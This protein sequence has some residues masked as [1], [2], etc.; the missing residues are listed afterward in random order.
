MQLRLRKKIKYS[1]DSETEPNDDDEYQP[2]LTGQ[3]EEE[4]EEEEIPEEMPE[5]KED[6]E[7]LYYLSSSSNEGIHKPAIIKQNNYKDANEEEEIDEETTTKQPTESTS[8]S[9]SQP[10]SQPTPQPTPQ[11]TQQPTTEEQI[12]EENEDN[13]ES[14]GE[15]E[16]ITEVYV[17]VTKSKLRRDLL[18][19]RILEKLDQNKFE[20]TINYDTFYADLDKDTVYH[21]LMVTRRLLSDCLQERML[22][23]DRVYNLMFYLNAKTHKQPT[24]YKRP[25]TD[26]EAA[27]MNIEEAKKQKELE[28][29]VAEEIRKK[30]DFLKKLHNAKDIVGEEVIN[31]RLQSEELNL[32]TASIQEI[33]TKLGDLYDKILTAGSPK[34]TGKSA[35]K[36]DEDEEDEEDE[37]E[38]DEDEKDEESKSSGGKQTTKNRTNHKNTPKD[39]ETQLGGDDHGPNDN[40]DDGKKLQTDETVT[41][42]SPVKTVHPTTEEKLLQL[43]QHLNHLCIKMKNQRLLAANKST[44][45]SMDESQNFN[46]D[47]FLNPTSPN[48]NAKEDDVTAPTPTNTTTTTTTN[49]TVDEINMLFKGD[50][51]TATFLHHGEESGDDDKESKAPFTAP[52]SSIGSSIGSSTEIKNKG[53]EEEKKKPEIEQYIEYIPA[54]GLNLLLDDNVNVE[55]GVNQEAENIPLNTMFTP[56]GSTFQ[57]IMSELLVS[58]FG[59]YEN[60]LI[61]F[62][63]ETLDGNTL[64][65]LLAS[66]VELIKLEKEKHSTQSY[67]KGSFYE[68]VFDALEVKVKKAYK[69]LNNYLSSIEQVAK[70]DLMEDEM[71]EEDSKNRAVAIMYD[72]NAQILKYILGGY[73]LILP[74]KLLE[75]GVSQQ[76]VDYVVNA[77]KVIYEPSGKLDK[78]PLTI[79]NKYIILKKFIQFISSDQAIVLYLQGRKH[80]ATVIG[81]IAKIYNVIRSKIDK[82]TFDNFGGLVNLVNWVKYSKT[83]LDDC[84]PFRLGET[85]ESVD[86]ILIILLES[87][88]GI[89]NFVL[90]NDLSI[91][92]IMNNNNNNNNTTSSEGNLQNELILF[93]DEDEEK[94]AELHQRELL[95][96]AE[97]ELSQR[98]RGKCSSSAELP[99]I[100]NPVKNQTNLS[101]ERKLS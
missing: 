42:T 38:E 92:T 96:R 17:P 37:D 9:T 72:L 18:P 31:L 64:R 7:E 93:D 88:P 91:I 1:E 78:N 55:S 34:K 26:A 28:N 15:E 100:M 41:V 65:L 25:I 66:T 98:Q 94:Q 69:Y 35:G 43:Q 68:S 97:E 75:C 57:T 56:F 10:T 36:G 4:E 101:S 99:V 29:Q 14:V 52:G 86:R 11:P 87:F 82:K 50:S 27:F 20:K 58:T 13:D 16:E 12:E 81:E 8:Q 76:V 59:D 39:D 24:G 95:R 23:M 21:Q 51:E 79:I 63:L 89:S 90:E 40:E 67:Y 77:L 70:E 71:E 54:E 74:L 22:F 73:R 85:I 61:R 33:Q 48:D 45:D 19:P 62:D 6:D 53:E 3:E 84:F 2:S 60:N 44:N 5:G 32:Q 30:N 46:T 80:F 49:T 83:I 47:E